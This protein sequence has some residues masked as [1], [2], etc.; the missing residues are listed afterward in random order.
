LGDCVAT[1]AGVAGRGRRAGR[2]WRLTKPATLML[3]DG[4]V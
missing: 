3:R 1:G 4:M 2:W